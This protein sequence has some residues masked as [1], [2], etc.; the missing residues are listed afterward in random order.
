VSASILA[1]AALAVVWCLIRGE[2]TWGQIVLGLIF[3]SLFVGSTRLGGGQSVPIRQLPKRFIFL[4]LYLIVLIYDI[5]QSN[6]EFA[7]RLLRRT[8]AIRPGIVRVRL[9]SIAEGTAELEAH[10]ITVAPGQMVV[11]YSQDGR[12]IYVHLI[13][14][15][16][17]D[18]KRTSIWRT[19]RALL[20]EVFS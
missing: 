2:F 1:A 20:H 9:G 5:V 14:V 17:A 8:P 11:D 4:C 6:L 13:D 15:T 16:A 7:G 12:T 3:A 10:A 19:Y 18:A